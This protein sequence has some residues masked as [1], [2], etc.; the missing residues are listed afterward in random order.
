MRS[1]SQI[2][3]PRRRVALPVRAA[4]VGLCPFVVLLA[5]SPLLPIVWDEGN[6]ISRAE[7]ME[8]WGQAWFQQGPPE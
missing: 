4:A 8:D 7:Q 5:T 3:I 1:P 6:A 2:P